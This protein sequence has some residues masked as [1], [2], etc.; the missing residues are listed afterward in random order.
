MFSRKSFLFIVALRT[1]PFSANT[2][3]HT[4]TPH[5]YMVQDS[6]GGKRVSHVKH[7]ISFHTFVHAPFLMAADCSIQPGCSVQAPESHDSLHANVF[8]LHCQKQSEPLEEPLE[9]IAPW[10]STGQ[11]GQL[12]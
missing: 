6:G 4:H 11:T 2:H 5:M 10:T 1:E 3:T 12:T 7:S 9:H 8:P